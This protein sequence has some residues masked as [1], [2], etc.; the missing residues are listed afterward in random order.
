[1]SKFN[2]QS[3][4]ID[5]VTVFSITGTIDQHYYTLFIGTK[6]T[7]EQL[8]AIEQAPEI[9]I[10]LDRNDTIFR[11]QHQALIQ[12]TTGTV[13]A[14]A[15]ALSQK[16]FDII[17]GYSYEPTVLTATTIT[18]K[19]SSLTVTTTTEHDTSQ[20]AKQDSK[21]PK[22]DSKEL[23]T[24]GGTSQE[25]K[26][27]SELK[28]DSRDNRKSGPVNEPDDSRVTH[29][30]NATKKG[31]STQHEGTKP[32]AGN[33][34]E[35]K[36]PA[37]SKSNNSSG[38]KERG[39]NSGTDSGARR[40]DSDRPNDQSSTDDQ[41]RDNKP[42]SGSNES[43][44]ASTKETSTIP[45]SDVARES[46]QNDFLNS[47]L[48]LI[49]E[50][51]TPYALPGVVE[52]QSLVDLNHTRAAIPTRSNIT[53]H[54]GNLKAALLLRMIGRNAHSKME[55]FQSI[56]AACENKFSTWIYDP[57]VDYISILGYHEYNESPYVNVRENY[58]NDESGWGMRAIFSLHNKQERMQTIKGQTHVCRQ[59]VKCP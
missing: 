34:S 33:E 43:K 4:Q 8:Q 23:P 12:D 49:G 59:L 3:L 56:F 47:K 42:K 13:S 35:G 24:E 17:N 45:K 31:D 44:N 19:D 7:A 20:T 11:S 54:E 53:D 38:Q 18:T 1:M 32:R 29:E 16:A 6:F 50:L 22:G 58:V 25:A 10:Q 52:R 14:K 48:L 37:D 40:G 57:V 2:V 36:R 55:P 46:D 27:D 5:R 9:K 26:D 51:L 28:Q 21:H 15:V 39:T 41:I 30:T